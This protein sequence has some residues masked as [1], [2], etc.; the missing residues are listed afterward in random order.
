MAV[1]QIV[2][3]LLGVGLLKA[4]LER[5]APWSERAQWVVTAFIMAIYTLGAYLYAAYPDWPRH[6][7]SW[8]RE[9]LA[10]N[11]PTVPPASGRITYYVGTAP[12]GLKAEDYSR[13]FMDVFADRGCKLSIAY[14]YDPSSNHIVVNQGKVIVPPD[15]NLLLRVKGIELWVLDPLH[16]P[17]A[18]EQMAHALT[19]AGISFVWRPDIRLAGIE[20]YDTFRFQVNGLDCI[21]FIGQKLPWSLS[22]SL[23]VQRRHFEWRLRMFRGWLSRLANITRNQTATFVASISRTGINLRK[24]W[25]GNSLLTGSQFSSGHPR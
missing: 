11:C 8:Q 25:S 15:E 14:G 18:A 23:Y 9:A 10:A 19:M 17:I 21:L 3:A 4:F 5:Y 20:A 13:E 16:P 2:G 7:A 12:S 24:L 6:L 1:V 22:S